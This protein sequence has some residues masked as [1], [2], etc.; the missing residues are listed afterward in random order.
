M[1]LISE[2]QLECIDEAFQDQSWIE[3]ME[4]ELN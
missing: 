2:I 4:E 3:A 1:A